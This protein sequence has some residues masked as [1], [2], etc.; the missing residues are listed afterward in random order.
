MGAGTD[1]D[2]ARPMR[3][4]TSPLS[5]KGPIAENPRPSAKRNL[6]AMGVKD[7]AWRYSRNCDQCY[8]RENPATVRD[9][10][11]SIDNEGNSLRLG[12]V[13]ASRD[14][15]AISPYVVHVVISSTSL[16]REFSQVLG[17]SPSGPANKSGDSAG[18]PSDWPTG[19]SASGSF[20]E[21]PPAPDHPH[22][23]NSPSPSP[24]TYVVSPPGVV[25]LRF[26]FM[27]DG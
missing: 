24:H 9:D 20:L 2:P 23:G 12:A 17:E 18:T 5:V 21:A 6:R 16:V 27:C 7:I 10:P 25:S 3:L 4:Q 14:P 15:A 26:P 8:A 19:P 22:S 13:S 1:D 11:L